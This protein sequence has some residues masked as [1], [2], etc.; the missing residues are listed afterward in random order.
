MQLP[1]HRQCRCSHRLNSNIARAVK[2]PRHC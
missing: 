2:R 1:R